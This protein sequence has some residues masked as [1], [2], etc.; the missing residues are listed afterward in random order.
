MRG[1]CFAGALRQS[2]DVVVLDP[3]LARVL[4]LWDGA[5]TPAGSSRRRWRERERLSG[6]G[7]PALDVGAGV[8]YLA[9][10]MKLLLTPFRFP[11][12]AGDPLPCSWLCFNLQ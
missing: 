5:E 1:I 6:L 2:G 9:L 7:H 3:G 10:L 11:A 8:R 12:D 4:Q